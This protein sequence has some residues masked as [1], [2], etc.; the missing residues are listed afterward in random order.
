[1]KLHEMTPD[2]I[3]EQLEL[4]QD[5]YIEAAEIEAKT[6][7][8][9]KQME[10]QMFKLYRASK[11]SI[12]DA[13]RSVIENEAFQ[14]SWEDLIDKQMAA[15]RARAAVERAKLAT[16]LYRTIRADQRRI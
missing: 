4:R 13:K 1:M 9:H 11:E 10:A 8:A 15:A 12:E 6:E 16:D 5:V 7:A 2:Q 14:T 3:L